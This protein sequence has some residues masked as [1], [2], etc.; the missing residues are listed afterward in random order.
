MRPGAERI[1]GDGSYLRRISQ[2]TGPNVFI[3]NHD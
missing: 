3:E 1:F 2:P